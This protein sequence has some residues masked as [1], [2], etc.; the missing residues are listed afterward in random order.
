MVVFTD[1]PLADAVRLNAACRAASPPVAFLRAEVRGV[2]GSAFADLGPSFVVAD[3]DGEQPHGA[4]V[5]GIT[6]GAAAEGG[7]GGV[8]R[9]LVSCVDDERLELQDGDFVVFSEVK[10][11]T[12]LNDG[13]PRRVVGVKAHSFMLEARGGWGRVGARPGF[14]VFSVVSHTCVL[15]FRGPG[16]HHRLRRVRVRRHGAAG[17][18][19]QDG[20]F[21]RTPPADRAPVPP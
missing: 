13:V 12:Q 11:M 7:G 3:T 20:A 10:G 14:L 4:I 19:A 17:E 18:A 21:A 1:C 6:A 16:G 9:T 8:G 15:L 5:A 2:F